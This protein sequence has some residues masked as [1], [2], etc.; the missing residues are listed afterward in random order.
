MATSSTSKPAQSALLP[1]PASASHLQREPS[2]EDLELAEQLVIHAKG[3]QPPIREQQNDPHTK[4]IPSGQTESASGAID[5]DVSR[6]TRSHEPTINGQTAAALSEPPAHGADDLPV[7]DRLNG[8]LGGGQV[9]S[10]CGTT[11]T[12]LWRRSPAGETIC[13]A[14]GLYLKARNQMRPT[15]LKRAQ[16]NAVLSQDQ[17]EGVEDE[18]ASPNVRALTGSATYIPADNTVSGTCPGGGRCNG[19]GGHDGCS[20]CPAYNNRVSKTA[21]FALAQARDESSQPGEALPQVVS[22]PYAHAQNTDGRPTA[23]VIVACQ[24][25]GTTVTPLWRRDDNGHTI[26]NACGESAMSLES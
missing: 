11:R 17:T 23:N 14:C 15:K 9:C 3:R 22:E 12:P 26:C 6:D 18:H 16:Q 8:T 1:S 24:N 4:S 25:C 7:T 5:S 13:N 20:G 10:N 19:T 2:K 21:Q